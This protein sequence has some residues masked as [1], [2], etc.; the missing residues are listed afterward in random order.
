MDLNDLAKKIDRLRV[1]AQSRYKS[2]ADEPLRTYAQGYHDA[3]GD[4]ANLL[5]QAKEAERMRQRLARLETD[6]AQEPEPDWSRAPE[7]NPDIKVSTKDSSLKL[8]VHQEAA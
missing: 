7:A 1:A 8:A 5:K 4:I 2:T 3:L 6:L